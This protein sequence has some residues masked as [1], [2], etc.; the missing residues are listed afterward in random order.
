MMRRHRLA[1][2]VAL[3]VSLAFLSPVAA[4]AAVAPGTPTNLATT[5]TPLTRSGAPQSCGTGTAYASYDNDGV[6][7]VNLSA[8]VNA[9]TDD[10][11]GYS[12][13]FYVTDET[14]GTTLAPV[15]SVGEAGSGTTVSVE[16][17]VTNGHA[18]SWTVADTDGTNWSA[19]AG[20]CDFISDLSAPTNPLVTSADFPPTGSNLDSGEP[21]SFTLTSTEAAPGP[22]VSGY[23]YSFDEI[24]GVGGPFTAA[25]SNGSLVLSGQSFSW[26]THTLYVQAD[27]AAGNVSAVT[28]YSFYV[29]QNP[30]L[31][32]ELSLTTNGPAEVSASGTG[33][34][35]T[36]PLTQCSFNFG[37]GS[38]PVTVPASSCTAADHEY[39]QDG[40]YPVTLTI[41]DQEGNT[42]SV[43][44]DFTTPGLSRGELFHEVLPAG[45]PEDWASPAGSTGLTQADITAMPN[46]SS[47]LVA[48]NS[49]GVLLHD[50]RFTTGSWQG[51][52]QLAQPGVT[53]IDAGIAGMP[54]GSS[55]VVEV[56]STGVLKHNIRNVN[57]TWQP[58][59]WGSPAGSTGI[60]QASIA[61][62]PNGSSQIL[63]VTTKGTLKL[64]IR[65]ANGSWQGWTTL[66]Q[67]GVTVSNAS[68]AGMPNGTSQ[69]VEVT[70][71]GDLEHN[72][73]NANGTWQPS[74]WS[75]PAGSS[76]GYYSRA[77]ITALPNGSSMIVAAMHE[78]AIE[79]DFRAANGSWNGWGKLDQ[80]T[81]VV[82]AGEISAAGMPNGTQQLIELSAI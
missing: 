22:G 53:V 50:I 58:F 7:V 52:N 62:M 81:D 29:P 82:R 79:D 55:Q 78:W 54:N 61:G 38:S 70:S 76:S 14:T 35:G 20:P 12:A 46:G 8:T 44:K 16:L 67:P 1:T 19:K 48:V 37:D 34:T 33:S 77:S 2:A 65:N 60:A 17:P 30:D 43:T 47:Q 59:G 11:G 45:Y 72:V 18:Y 28:Q 32:P 13:A 68:I 40:T 75:V 73:R 21:G 36:F 3:S 41:T 24:L 27:D 9:G 25:N 63:A 56:T 39:S 26:G 15:D 74:G 4:H 5:P 57:G 6:D 51:W 64:D 69:L 49:K 31:A 71:T 80:S 23:A 66:A 42:K 10:A